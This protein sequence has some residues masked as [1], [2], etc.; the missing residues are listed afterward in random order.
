MHI[1]FQL[2]DVLKFDSTVVINVRISRPIS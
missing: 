2:S 1:V